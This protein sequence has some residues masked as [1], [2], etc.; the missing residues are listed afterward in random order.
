MEKHICRTCAVRYNV[1]RNKKW[2]AIGKCSICHERHI[3][4]AIKQNFTLK[5]QEVKK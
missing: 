3:L 4:F 1:K 5:Q 2:S